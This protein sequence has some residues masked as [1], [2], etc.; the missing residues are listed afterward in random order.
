MVNKFGNFVPVVISQNGGNRFVKQ[1]F[2][3]AAGEGRG[4]AFAEH[5]VPGN[6]LRMLII[7]EQSVFFTKAL[8]YQTNLT[9]DKPYRVVGKNAFGHY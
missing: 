5:C 8:T 4:L 2:H 7:T 3:K 9:A 1:Q 6:S